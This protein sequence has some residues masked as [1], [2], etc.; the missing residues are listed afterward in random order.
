MN[1]LNATQIYELAGRCGQGKDGIQDAN[2]EADL[3][4]W[5]TLRTE[6]ISEDTT[7]NQLMKKII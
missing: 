2:Q 4:T 7:E 3:E 6:A 5:T 1:W